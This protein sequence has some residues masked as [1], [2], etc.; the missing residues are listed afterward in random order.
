M[1]KSQVIEERKK[2][3]LKI[4]GQTT[5]VQTSTGE[6]RRKRQNPIFIAR[7]VGEACSIG[8]VQILGEKESWQQIIGWKRMEEHGRNVEI[9]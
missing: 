5:T 9:E 7:Q 6:K 8:G 4:E 1:Q 3:I 2:V